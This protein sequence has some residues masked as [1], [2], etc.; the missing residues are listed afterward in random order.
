[1]NWL[2]MDANADDFGKTLLSVMDKDT[3]DEWCRLIQN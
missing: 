1:M 3:L 2:G